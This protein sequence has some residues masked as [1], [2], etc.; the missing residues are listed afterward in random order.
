MNLPSPSQLRS[1]L[2]VADNLHFGAAADECGIS[3]PALSAQLAKLESGLGVQLVERTTRR[4][5]LTPVGEEVVE[6]ARSVLLGLEELTA[7]A[8]RGRAPLTGAFYLGVIPTVAPYVLPM[9]LPEVRKAFPELRLFLREEQTSRLVDS[10]TRGKLDVALL[11]LP[12]DNPGLQTQVIG[13]ETF[14]LV[15]PSGHRLAS[16]TAAQLR[17]IQGEEVLLLEDGHCFRDQ[18]LAVCTSA[19]ARETSSIR[20]NS[21]STLVHMVANGLGLT[22]LPASAAPLELRGVSDVV[23]IAFGD[24]EPKRT[25]G[26]VWRN[27]SARSDEFRAF[28]D[29][30]SRH[31]VF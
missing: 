9:L 22:L 29:F 13:E 4:V 11:A 16:S 2:A 7:V 23:D 25:L 28:G 3:Q 21:I 31:L 24:P 18:A 1:L 12:I 14:R 17:D 19:G 15:V 5:F 30:L 26:L 20:A 6:R 10:L 8:Q 27:S